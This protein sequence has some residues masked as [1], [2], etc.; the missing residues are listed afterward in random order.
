MRLKLL[1][2]LSNVEEITEK[3]AIYLKEDKIGAIPTETFYGLACNPFSEKALY[4]LTSLK[5][6]KSNKP[7]LLLINSL[8]QLKDLVKE[9]PPLGKKLIEKFWPGPLTIVFES[10]ESLSPFLTANTNTI[11]VRLSSSFIVKKIIEKF[12]YPVTGTSANLS[13]QPPCKTPEE[14]LRQIPDIDFI[15]DAGELKASLP[16]TVV[17]VVKNKLKLI[18]E[19]EIPYKKILEVINETS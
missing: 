8:E 11:G 10:K 16:S 5:K 1:S 7:I 13:D 18:R 3:V 12:G 6:R 2:D 4:K 19:G 14:V 9:I 15:I 17:C